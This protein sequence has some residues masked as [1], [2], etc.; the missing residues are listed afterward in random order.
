VAIAL[1]WAAFFIVPPAGKPGPA[2]RDFEAFFSA[3]TVANRGEDP[4][5]RAIWSAERTVPGVDDSHDEALPFVGPS[6]GLLLWRLLARLPYDIAGRVWG[7]ILALALLTIVFGTASLARAPR[8]PSVV[9]GIAIFAGAFGPLSSGVALGQVALLAAAGIVGSLV[10][11]RSRAWLAA[12]IPALVGALQPSLILVLVARATDR[13]ALAAFG[14]GAA[15]FGALTLAS[16][17]FA[18]IVRYLQLLSVHGA[19]EAATVIQITPAAIARGFGT[20][21]GVIAVV[22]FG[23]AALTAALTIAAAF[24]LRD[25]TLRVC[26][27]SC[28]LLFVIPFVHEHDFVLLVLP[29]LYCAIRARGA[30]LAFAAIAATACGVDWLGLAQRP[31]SLG[32]SLALSTACALGFALA[33]GL[34]RASWTGLCIPFAVM[35]AALLARAHPVPVWPDT[36]PLHWQPP[37]GATI[38]EVWGLEQRAAGLDARNAAWSVLRALTLLSAALLGIATW[39]TGKQERGPAPELSL[40]GEIT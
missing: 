14:T 39:M 35:A 32:Q 8:R 25:P 17:G 11:L 19:S 4:Y 18:G 30:T 3:G 29:A 26:V 34:R 12:A 37:A 22:R 6:A 5:G 23:S 36:L 38:S 9:L 24:H 1:L 27:A 40:E 10:L 2:M 21:P 28:G 15:L 31:S 7:A 33:A 20:P 13:R 16:G